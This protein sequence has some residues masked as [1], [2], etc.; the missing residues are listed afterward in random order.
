MDTFDSK[1][2]VNS[3][4]DKYNIPGPRYTSYPT[5]PHWN[6]NSFNLEAWKRSVS[7][8]FRKSNEISVY[9]HLPFCESLCTFCGCHKRITKRHEVEEPYIQT[10]IK[11]W[12]LYLKL[13]HRTPEIKELHLGGG[14]PTFFAPEALDHLLTQ[15]FEK[16]KRAKQYS[17]SFE[18][19]PS[20][21]NEAHLSTLKKHGF[22]RV[23][24]GIQDYSPTVQKAIHRIQTLDQVQNVTH[25]ARALG[26]ESVGHDLIYGLPLQ[27]LDHIKHTIGLTLK[28]RPERIAL[29]SYAHV[30]WVKG[31]G[32]RGF[33][34]AELPN[35][36]EK[37]EQYQWA[38]KAL[39]QGGYKDVGMDHFA[40]KN[41]SLAIAAENGTLHRNFM[42]YTT[43]RTDLMIGLG[44]SSISDSWGGF[45][46][47]EKDLEAYTDS[48]QRGIIPVFRGHL[49]SEEDLII[50]K[51]ILN[52]MTRFETHWH[53]DENQFS[54]LG[55]SL[56]R[57][58][59]LVDDDLVEIFEAGLRVTKK[60]EPFIRNLA[61]AFDQHLHQKTSEKKRFSMT[62]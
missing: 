23:S 5:V 42:G 19:H 9:I 36:Q 55:D 7:A 15:L 28:M 16:A 47:N 11:E 4:I 31:T 34:E 25:K 35:A 17:Y 59:G 61:M 8:A 37:Q 21:T 49:L 50:R 32:Q 10:L 62:V 48:I 33:T 14:T 1:Y 3:L 45:A 6:P 24:Y 29:Y 41:D 44:M 43:E 18:G 27:T 46:Q 30:P 22:S 60:G 39:L 51:H 12:E 2:S 20:S 56:E 40:L 26:Y 52:I 54:T 38:K 58:K 53:S 57:L 13:F